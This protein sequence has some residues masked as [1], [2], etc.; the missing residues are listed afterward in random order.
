[1]GQGYARW[2][3]IAYVAKSKRR[4]GVASAFWFVERSDVLC[5][6][7]EKCGSVAP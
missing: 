1:M 4:G 3:W 7:V 6:Q 5:A 2:R